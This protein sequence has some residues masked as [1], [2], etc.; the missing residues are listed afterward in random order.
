MRDKNDNNSVIRKIPREVNFATRYPR[1]SNPRSSNQSF[2]LLFK[3]AVLT[4]VQDV[5]YY[6]TCILLFKL[7]VLTCVYIYYVLVHNPY[8]NQMYLYVGRKNAVLLLQWYEPLQKFMIARVRLFPLLNPFYP[9]TNRGLVSFC[10]SSFSLYCCHFAI[11]LSESFHEK[12]ASV[13]IENSDYD[14]FCC[15]D[16]EKT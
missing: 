12:L 13:L 16:R 10:C 7:A 11:F 6:A 1:S 2:L 15:I 4:Y 9:S 5:I 8:N 3:L 14:F